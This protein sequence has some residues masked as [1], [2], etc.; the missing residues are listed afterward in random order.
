MDQL[1]YV[2]L[3]NKKGKWIEVGISSDNMQEINQKI[4]EKN[5]KDEFR[6]IQKYVKIPKKSRKVGCCG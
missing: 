4:I 3:I 6:I 2:V 1:H 5:I